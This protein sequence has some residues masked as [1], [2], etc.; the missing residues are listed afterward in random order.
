[1]TIPRAVSGLVESS[2][3]MPK[4]GALAS[5]ASSA[6]LRKLVLARSKI[7]TKTIPAAKL[8]MKE[9]ATIKRRFGPDGDIGGEARYIICALSLA[10]GDLR[11]FSRLACVFKTGCFGICPLSLTPVDL[12]AFSS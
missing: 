1:M 5:I 9:M 7:K 2:A 12:R 4:H 8:Q 10:L 11:E 3:K 6:S